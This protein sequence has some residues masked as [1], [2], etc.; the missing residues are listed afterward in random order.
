MRGRRDLIP[1]NRIATGSSEEVLGGFPA[2]VDGQAV[3]VTAVLE[4]T[5][6]HH[7][8]RPIQA[9]QCTGR[10]KGHQGRRICRH[11]KCSRSGRRGTRER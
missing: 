7:T 11:P 8:P 9:Q 2:I 10:S 1:L 3:W 5:A 6:V 4:R